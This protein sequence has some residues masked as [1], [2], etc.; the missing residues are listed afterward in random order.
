MKTT[1][2]EKHE[3]LE[4]L[5]KK[6]KSG[7]TVFCILRHV[8]KSGMTRVIDLLINDEAGIPQSISWLFTRVAD[9]S[10]VND[11]LYGIRVSGCGMDMGFELVYNLGR[12]LWPEGVECVGQ[13]CRS[14][15]HSNGDRNYE[16]QIHKDGG[17]AL[18]HRWL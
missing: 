3:A 5:R 14:N 2:Q 18:N 8:S 16:K 15:D 12:I 7:D 4:L 1:K 17:Y 11:R 6:L 10:M 13:K 9:Y